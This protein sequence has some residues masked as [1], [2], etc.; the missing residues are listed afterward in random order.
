[1]A[2]SG[3]VISNKYNSA[4]WSFEWTSSEVSPGKTKVNWTLYA[5]GRNSSPTQY[6]TKIKLYVN[7]KVEFER[8]D[9]SATFTGTKY[10]SGSFTVTHDETGK[11]T[12]TTRLYVSKI[13]DAVTIPSTQTI[14][15][16][17]NKPYSN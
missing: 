4:Y 15:L 17:T 9:E 8:W 2:S 1:M 16:D 6:V 10:D 12:F 7:G 11:G 14:T 5:K 3:K 13:Y